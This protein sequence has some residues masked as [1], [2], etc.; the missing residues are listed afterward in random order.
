MNMKP[1]TKPTKK[2]GKLLKGVFEAIEEKG[3]YLTIT[4]KDGIQI[5]KALVANPNPEILFKNGTGDI[6]I[7][8][9][10]KKD[11]ESKID[12]IILGMEKKTTNSKKDYIFDENEIVKDKIFTS[13]MINDTL[14]GFGLFLI[15]YEP[16]I[17]ENG[18]VIGEHQVEKPVIITSDRRIIPA[19]RRTEADLGIRYVSIPNRLDLRWR[20]R[21][22]ERWI[23]RE[24]DV[25]EVNGENLFDMIKNQYKKYN[26]YRESMW[27]DV[28]ALWDMAT[29]LHQLFSSFAIKEERGLSG[30]GKS[31]TLRVSSLIALNSTELMTNP[32]VATL[33][34]ETEEKH[35]SKQFDEAET[36]FKRDLKGG[37]MQDDR[38]ELINASYSRNGAVPRQEAKSKG[39]GYNTIWYHVYSPTRISSINGLF[40]ATESRAITQVHTKS[41]DYDGRGENDPEN[42]ANDEVWKNIRDLCYMWALQN[43]SDVRDQYL[44]FNDDTKLKK[45][46]LQLWKPLI[47]M[48]KIINQKELEPNLI[49]FAEKLSKQRHIDILSEG[50][51]D[52]QALECMNEIIETKPDKDRIYVNRIRELLDIKYP[53]DALK[54]DRKRGKGYNKT[55]SSKLD[56]LGFGELKSKDDKGAYYELTKV[57]FDSIAD[58][59]TSDFHKKSSDS[60]YSSSSDDKQHKIPDDDLTNITNNGNNDK[61]GIPDEKAESDESKTQVSDDFNRQYT[62]YS[63]ENDGNDGKSPESHMVS[64]SNRNNYPIYV[65]KLLKEAKEKDARGAN[66]GSDLASMP[67]SEE[68][69][70]DKLKDAIK[71]LVK[72]GEVQELGGYW[73]LTGYASGLNEVVE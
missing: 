18:A 49:K 5:Q 39:K 20:L 62:S 58:T 3:F 51:L 21:S 34:R 48:A 16:T 71:W 17:D 54:M 59:L 14:F 32:S 27:Y 55:I 52:Y 46:D 26:Y 50:S 1:N 64:T 4:E 13:D 19:D 44:N 22:I 2:I 68:F 9:F 37:I 30:T 7:F 15:R 43:W 66:W 12:E 24:V 73:I 38:V 31:K 35:P 25:E 40:G 47:A 56:K 69:E 36:L 63:D 8:A 42:D 53:L 61:S 70:A 11:Y 10:Y 45:R 29:Y 28:N 23:D 60:S 67:I 6:R 72:Q 65:I 57:V 33:F 41:P